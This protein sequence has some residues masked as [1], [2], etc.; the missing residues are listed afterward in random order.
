VALAVLPV[1]PILRACTDGA[2]RII[3]ASVSAERATYRALAGATWGILSCYGSK[4]GWYHAAHLPLILVEMEAGSPSF[5]GAIDELSLVLVCAGICAGNLAFGSFAR[6]AA[7]ASTT[8]SQSDRALCLRG[9][10]TNMWFGDFVE[11]CYPYMES[12]WAVNAGGYIGSALSSA[13]LVVNATDVERVPKSLAYLPLP[14]SIALAGPNWG[15]YSVSC[16]IAF[17]IPFV[18]TLLHRLTHS[19]QHQHKTS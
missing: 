4:V 5:L 6:G 13:W 7:G 10:R 11:C 12:S 9:L 16:I 1:A 8:L 2:R 15:T 17:V 19:R 14:L 18:A 3:L